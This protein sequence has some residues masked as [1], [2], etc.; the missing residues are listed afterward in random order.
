ETGIGKDEI[1]EL[2]RHFYTMRRQI[3]AAQ[4][5]IAAEQQAKEYII[6]TISHD[7]KTPLTSI[8]AYAESLDTD[9]ELSEEQQRTY[10]KVIVEKADFIKQMIDD[11]TM[12]SILQS[13]D[14]TLELVTVEGE[15]FFEM[16]VSDYAPLSTHKQIKLI[17]NNE[18]TGLYEVH[19]HQ[20]VRVVDNLV[21]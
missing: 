1:G 6:A 9:G 19:P 7:L 16:L 18:V 12:H 11:L 15:E 8:K 13:Q 10:R 14:F 2:K 3:V 20:L 21:M 17:A 5:K 4:Q